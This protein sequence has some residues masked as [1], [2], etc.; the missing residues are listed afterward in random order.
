MAKYFE[1]KPVSVLGVNTDR[2]REDAI[3]VIEKKNPS[4]INISGRDL[5]KKYGVTNY[6]TFIVIDRNGLV[7]RILIGYEPELADTLIEIVELLL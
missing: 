7:R 3:F 2:E 4:Y 5:I 6:P 1:G